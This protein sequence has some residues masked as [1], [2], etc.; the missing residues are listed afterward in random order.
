MT[1]VR[2]PSSA[3]SLIFAPVA[4]LVEQDPCKVK[5]I[6]SIPIRGSNF[7]LLSGSKEVMS[8]TKLQV[9]FAKKAVKSLKEY[10]KL[11]PE[12]IQALVETRVP[13]NEN[14]V[15]HPSV[16]VNCED[17]PSVGLLGILNGIVGASS[18]GSTTIVAMYSMDGD[19]LDF[20]LTFKE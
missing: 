4:Q 9:E 13:A 6:G 14:L 17:Q 3:Q 7:G 15:S 2:I 16:Q 12:A 20:G 19:L 11:D 18:L 10:L 1:R 5:V 8:Q